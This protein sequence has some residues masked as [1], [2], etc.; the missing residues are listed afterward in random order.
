MLQQFPFTASPYSV[1]LFFRGRMRNVPSTDPGF[2]ELYA[3]LK[4]PAHDELVIERLV[5]KP[6]LLE[7]L[8]VGDVKVIGNLVYYKGA[9]IHSALAV[10]LLTMI[11]AG[12]D[13][14]NWA[15]FL[16]RVMENP[17]ERSRECLYE[18]LDKWN[19]PI[20]EDGHFIAFKKVRGDFRDIHSGTMDNSPG[21]TVSMDRELVNADPDQTCSRGLHVAA[22]SYLGTYSSTNG[23]RVLAL[24]VDPADV[25]AVP[26]DYG[27]AKMR[28]CRYLVL[29]EAEES[30]Y[31]TADTIQVYNVSST[32]KSALTDLAGRRIAADAVTFSEDWLRD[33]H[34]EIAEGSTVSPTAYSGDD[35][36]SNK[37][38]VGVVTTS[39]KTET[40]QLVDVE[41]QDGSTSASLRVDRTVPLD[42]DVV[43]V[44]FIGVA[45]AAT[46]SDEAEDEDP[47]DR[48]CPE[49]GDY[50][51][52]WQSICEDCQEER[53]DAEVCDDC[54]NAEVVN[55]GLCSGCFAESAARD[56]ETWDNI[57]DD[58][59]EAEHIAETGLTRDGEVPTESQLYA[60]AS[61]VGSEAPQAEK[62]FA[63]DGVTFTASAIKAGVQEHGQRGFARFTGIPRTTIQEWLKAIG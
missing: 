3:H 24:K 41:W 31:K 28:V 26:R 33:I 56:A 1:A 13:A 46:P 20:T 10:R 5:D 63:K 16:A 4:L 22:T 7:R 49:C 62:T 48:T 60:A 25:V 6:A 34:V 36:P 9:V 27:S 59:D 39:V 23:Y 35:L 52:D 19:A 44:K 43:A 18:F 29:G 58:V 30:F 47:E 8:T 55:D 53:D 54:G 15:R 51:A 12:F 57:R 45:T 14:S 37:F 40:G 61:Y 50:K 17:S 2:P 42:S 32:V 38:M 11:E 21:Q